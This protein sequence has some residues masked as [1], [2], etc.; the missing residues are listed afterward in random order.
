MLTDSNQA[1]LASS[2]MSE[3]GWGKKSLSLRLAAGRIVIQ[4]LAHSV[5][6]HNLAHLHKGNY[7][8]H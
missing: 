2:L 3:R 1:L 5:R 8:A 7:H 4:H 6:R